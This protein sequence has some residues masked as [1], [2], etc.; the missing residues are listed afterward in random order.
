[1]AFGATLHLVFV[2]SPLQIDD[3]LHDYRGHIA[4]VCEFSISESMSALWSRCLKA[5]CIQG[6]TVSRWTSRGM[7]EAPCRSFSECA[8]RNMHLPLHVKNDCD[9]KQSE[10]FEVV[11]ALIFRRAKD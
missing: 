4:A 1:M 5:S 3:Y 8:C 6:T 9:R 7:Y 2:L 11:A 10:L